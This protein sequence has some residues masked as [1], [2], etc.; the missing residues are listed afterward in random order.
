MKN[1]PVLNIVHE[2]NNYFLINKPP[3]VLSQPGNVH[4]WIYHGI[5][6]N[7]HVNTPKIVLDELKAQSNCRKSDYDNWR[8]I[9][10]LDSCVSGGLL[11]ATNKNA[12]KY[13]SRNLKEGGNKGFKIDRRYVAMV[14]DKKTCNHNYV[15]DYGIIKKMG[16]ISKYRRFDEKCILLELVTGQKH[17]IRKHLSHVIGQPVLNDVKYGGPLIPHT[18]PLQIALHAAYIKTKIGLKKR[19]H[20]IPMTFNNDGELWDRRYLDEQGNFIPEIQ[21]ML[22]EEWEF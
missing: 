4:R 7:Q 3:N 17:Q 13:F 2:C 1:K 10:R 18:D 15:N 8:L 19:E 6:K 21:K 20:L 5:Y 11:I 22:L 14:D 12:A 16:M 9:H